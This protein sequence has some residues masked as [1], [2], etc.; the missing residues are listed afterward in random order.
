MEMDTISFLEADASS[1]TGLRRFV[2]RRQGWLS[3]P[4]LPLRASTCTIRGCGTWCSDGA[5][6]PPSASSG[7]PTD[8]ATRPRG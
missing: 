6:A 7:S 1:A 3:F 8:G 2:T 5:A 4:L